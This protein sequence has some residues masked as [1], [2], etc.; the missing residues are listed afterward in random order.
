MAMRADAYLPVWVDKIPAHWLF[1]P[2]GNL[3]PKLRT[4]QAHGVIRVVAGAEYC[5]LRIDIKRPYYY[6]ETLAR[7]AAFDQQTE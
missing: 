6:P 3:R 1:L 7:V 5:H 4:Y 2:D